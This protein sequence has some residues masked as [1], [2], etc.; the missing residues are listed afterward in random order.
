MT[1]SPCGCASRCAARCAPAA[2]NAA[3]QTHQ[4]DGDAVEHGGHP[5]PRGKH[6][7]QEHGGRLADVAEPVD[8]EGAALL[9]GRGPAG[10]SSP[11]PIANDDP[12]MPRKNATISRLV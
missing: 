2:P 8:A 10:D 7:A 9:L 1:P 5:E 6:R 4:Q 12:A 11:T 3:A